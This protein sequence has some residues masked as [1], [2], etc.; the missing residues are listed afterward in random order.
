MV[1]DARNICGFGRP[2]FFLV[3]EKPVWWRFHAPTHWGS[4]VNLGI[5]KAV[6]PDTWEITKYTDLLKCSVVNG[7][8]MPD[9]HESL[10]WAKNQD[11]CPMS[12]SW[13]SC[14]CSCGIEERAERGEAGWCPQ[15]PAIRGLPQVSD[16]RAQAHSHCMAKGEP[17]VVSVWIY[18]WLLTG[19][20]FLNVSKSYSVCF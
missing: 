13:H 19:F 6:L 10:F 17:V 3:T 11:A 5:L 9:L 1:W 14:Y 16:P 20:S 8:R 12:L 2:Q 15:C 4:P 7:K 18:V